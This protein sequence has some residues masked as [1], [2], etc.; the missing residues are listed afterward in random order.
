MQGVR[1]T[2]VLYSYRLP[3]SSF[4]LYV[5]SDRYDNGSGATLN[6]NPAAAASDYLYYILFITYLLLKKV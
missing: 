3:F 6:Y 1:R 5:H 4:F 2:R